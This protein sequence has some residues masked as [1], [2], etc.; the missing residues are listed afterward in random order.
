VSSHILSDG[1]NTYVIETLGSHVRTWLNGQPCVDLDDPAGARRGIVALQLHSG[2][3]PKI[4]FRK[5]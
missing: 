2:G 3:P 1:W 4:R 5:I